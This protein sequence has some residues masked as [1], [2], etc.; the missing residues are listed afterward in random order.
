MVSTF[1]KRHTLTTNSSLLLASL[2]ACSSLLPCGSFALSPDGKCRIICF[3]GGG[4]HGAYEAGALKAITEMS[5]PADIHWDVVSG[6]SIGGMVGSI[7]ASHE[8]GKED[9]AAEKIVKMF[10]TITPDKLF[11]FWP[12]IILETFKESSFTD[13]SKLKNFLLDNPWVYDWKR[14]F[15]L[16]AVDINSGRVMFFDETTPF[17][18]RPMGLLGSAS[19][20]V[21]FPP[22]DTQVRGETYTMIDGGTFANIQIGEAVD[23]CREQVFSD[24][25]II[26]DVLLCGYKTFIDP[27]E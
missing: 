5:E 18:L 19:V 2:F 20:P 6:V 22:V 17:D 12:T 16:P 27:W 3:K 21:V 13:S 4:I 24:A 15:V 9:A 10:S 8:F 1:L 7:L 14:Q 26:L 25:D 23:R 11:D